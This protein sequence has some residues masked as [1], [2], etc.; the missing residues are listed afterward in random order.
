MERV[1]PASVRRLRDPIRPEHSAHNVR[2]VNS[3]GGRKQRECLPSL[4]PSSPPTKVKQRPDFLRSNACPWIASH[5]LPQGQGQRALPCSYARSVLAAL[6]DLEGAPSVTPARKRSFEK[7]GHRP[8][9][10]NPSCARRC[11]PPSGG[12]GCSM[13]PYEL[14]RPA[15][16]WCCVCDL[17]RRR[18]E[19]PA[20]DSRPP[21][22][23]H[24]P[25]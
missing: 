15:G 19:I 17:H 21:R 9:P 22:V 12:F 13:Q 25:Q 5:D 8:S 16:A 11:R 4:D 14:G 1:R 7:P 24:Q 23:G 6:P 2:Y 3:C 18:G 10:S 20:T